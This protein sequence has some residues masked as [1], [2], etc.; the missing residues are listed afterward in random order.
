MSEER[1]D[2]ETERLFTQC[3]AL[4]GDENSHAFNALRSRIRTLIV[5][6]A[7]RRTAAACEILGSGENTL[8]PEEADWAVTGF[9]THVASFGRSAICVCQK[10]VDLQLKLRRI[11]TAVTT[12]V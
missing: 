8:T 6:E 3:Y 9:R 11:S 1:L 10:C 12:N 2:D 4:D 5:E 7:L